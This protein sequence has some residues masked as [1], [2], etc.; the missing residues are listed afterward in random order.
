MH[1]DFEEIRKSSIS[2]SVAVTGLN[3][4]QLPRHKTVQINSLSENEMIDWIAASCAIP[5]FHKGEKIDNVYYYDGGIITR[6]PIEGMNF[7]QLDHV[8]HLEGFSSLIL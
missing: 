3:G 1:I 4:L 5:V 7:G 6:A 2:L 8:I